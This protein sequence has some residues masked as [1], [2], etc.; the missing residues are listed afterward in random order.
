M[1]YKKELEFATEMA[2]LAGGI[3][4]KYYR[5]NQQVEIKSDLSP[6]TIADKEINHLLIEHVQRQFSNHGVLG[7]EESWENDRNNLWVCDPIDGTVPYI[8]HV[9]TSVFSLALV[10]DGVPVV[11]VVY[12]PWV[13]EL[14]TAVKGEGAYRNEELIHVSER[15][16][17]AG[18]RIS[19]PLTIEGGLIPPEEVKALFKQKIYVSSVFGLVHGCMTVADGAIEARIFSYHTPHDIAAA[20]LIVEEAGG[21]VTD[22]QGDDQRYDRRINGAI[23][24]NG[25]VHDELLKLVKTSKKP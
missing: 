3:M 20:K 6:V 8:L 22:L 14:Y 9:P 16:W 17:G 5:N 21:K 13:D 15:K 2:K 11:A 18:V 25:L 4:K 1:D 23:V 19:A 7:E 24:T 12:N 10:I